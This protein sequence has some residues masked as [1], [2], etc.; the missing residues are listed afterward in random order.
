MAND[1]TTARFGLM[2]SGFVSTWCRDGKER[3]PGNSHNNRLQPR[4]ETAMRRIP[5]RMTVKALHP[6]ASVAKHQRKSFM[7]KLGSLQKT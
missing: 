1:P 2:R 4:I 7:R 5:L 3:S 6:S